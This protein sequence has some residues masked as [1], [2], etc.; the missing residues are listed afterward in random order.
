MHLSH[1]R[2]F[3]LEDRFLGRVGA[4]MASLLPLL[5]TACGPAPATATPAPSPGDVMAHRPPWT[6]QTFGGHQAHEDAVV[7]HVNTLRKGLGLLPLASDERLRVA[8]RQ[9]TMEMIQKGY[10]AHDSPVAAWKSPAQRACHAG[11]LE[12]FVSENIGLI[13][14]YPDVALA[15]F[16]SWKGSPGHYRNM[17]DPKVSRIGVGARATQRNGVTVWLATQLFGADP[18]DLRGLAVATVKQRVLRVGVTLD[19]TGDLVVKAWQGQQ[20]AGDVPRSGTRHTFQTD[21]P[22]PIT[23]TERIGFAVKVGGETPLVCAHVDVSP[24]EVLKTGHADFHPLCRRI[25]SIQARREALQVSRRVLSGEALA[26]APEALGARFFLN[27][28]WGPPLSLRRGQWTRF[29]Q[30]LPDAAVVDFSLILTR[31]Q[32]DYLRLDFR[33]PDPFLCP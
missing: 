26:K 2:F 4:L 15:L 25:L 16:E 17:V 12:P 18:L 5:V 29:S 6:G 24:P 14:G 30:P 11:Y 22:L 31:L 1:R 23:R 13:T 19:T 28:I 20:F 3:W 32:K 33:R 8:A 7:V 21:L 10:Y 9:H 27:R